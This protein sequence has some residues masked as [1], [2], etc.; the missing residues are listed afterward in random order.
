MSHIETMPQLI[1][2]CLALIDGPVESLGKTMGIDA[3]R[4]DVSEKTLSTIRRDIRSGFDPLGEAYMR[5]R[6]VKDRRISGE[7]Y[8]P[9]GVVESMVSWARQNGNP[10]RIVDCGCGSGRFTIAAAR[11]FPDARIVAVDNSPVA[12]LMARANVSVLGLADRCDFVL[13]DF[14]TVKIPHSHLSTLWIGN[15]P[16]VR[17]H[18]LSSTSKEWLNRTAITLGFSVSQLAGLHIYFIASIAERMKGEDYGILVLSAEWMD[19]NYGS[20]ARRLLNEKMGLSLIAGAKPE[21]KVFANAATTAV[22]V[23]FGG[24]ET[25]SSHVR[26]GSISPS[27]KMIVDEREIS[28]EK[29]SSAQRWNALLFGEA[30]AAKRE[31]YVRLGEI[32]RVHRG[33]VTGANRFWVREPDDR[34]PDELTIP[35]IAHA[36]ELQTGTDSIRNNPSL[37]RLICLPSDFGALDSRVKAV[38]DGLVASGQALGIDKGYVASRRRHWWSIPIPEAAP[39]LLT[40]MARKSPTF[41]LNPD[42]LRYL[43]VVHGIYPKFGLSQRALMNLVRHLNETVTV[44]DGRTYAGGL[45]KFEPREVE[46]LLVPS[47]EELEA[48]WL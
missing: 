2:V 18:A 41:V 11:A 45:T 17:H 39:I 15:P 28:R 23:G 34:L 19:T 44:Y 7:T 13:G 22:V 42:G 33:I 1:F 9:N 10:Q 6:N 46:N 4:V 12:I 29:L 14:T 30:K 26:L 32:A 48:A 21:T 24:A 31:G 27:G 35:V 20:F 43:N 37:T 8:T 38:A 5:L 16:Y 25:S 40:Y 3:S 36:R 47:L